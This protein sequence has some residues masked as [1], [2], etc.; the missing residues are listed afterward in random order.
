[1]NAN[2]ER[3]GLGPAPASGVDESVFT[4]Q[5]AAVARK[6]EA[7]LVDQAVAAR[8]AV[9]AGLDPGDAGGVVADQLDRADAL[10]QRSVFVERGRVAIAQGTGRMSGRGP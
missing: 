9:V 3:D 5:R 1:M 2:R 10:A 6:V 8:I 7:A 4:G